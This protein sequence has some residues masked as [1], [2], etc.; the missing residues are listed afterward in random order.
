MWPAQH[1]DWPPQNLH[2]YTHKHTRTHKLARL[3]NAREGYMPACHE[4]TVNAA[5]RGITL[6]RAC[7]RHMHTSQAIQYAWQLSTEIFQLPPERIWVSVYEDDDEAYQ[8][9]LEGVGVPAERIKRMDASSNFWASG[10]TGAA[11]CCVHGAAAPVSFL[12]LR[13]NM[14]SC[15]ACTLNCAWL[16]SCVCGS[17]PLSSSLCKQP[18]TTRPSCPCMQVL[19]LFSSFY[20]YQVWACLYHKLATQIPSLSCRTAGGGE[21]AF[22]CLF[23][24]L[25]H[26]LAQPARRHQDYPHPK[27]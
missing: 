5:Q 14:H 22:T 4:G 10:A 8:L 6:A 7:P 11:V 25:L 23:T 3:Q 12:A 17:S 13:E 21:H 1:C 2:T 18:G 20:S 15:P 24:P 9:W 16:H 19:H 27:K 26:E